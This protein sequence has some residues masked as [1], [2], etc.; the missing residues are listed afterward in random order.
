MF[1]L[2]K[3]RRQNQQLGLA[4]ATRRTQ[5]KLMQNLEVGDFIR[6]LGEPE[7]EILAR[8]KV[9]RAIT[10][11][12]KSQ[13]S[14]VEE[15][16]RTINERLLAYKKHLQDNPVYGIVWRVFDQKHF[17]SIHGPKP[18]LP[19]IFRLFPWN[20]GLLA[21]QIKQL[22]ASGQ[23]IVNTYGLELNCEPDYLAGLGVD[24]YKLRE[25]DPYLI[26]T[27]KK[28]QLEEILGFLEKKIKIFGQRV[29]AA[30]SNPEEV[31]ARLQSESWN[32]DDIQFSSNPEERERQLKLI[33][34]LDARKQFRLIEVYS[35]LKQAETLEKRLEARYTHK[36]PRT[37][38]YAILPVALGNDQ[39]YP[40]VAVHYINEDNLEL[41][42]SRVGKDVAGRYPELFGRKEYGDPLQ[43]FAIEVPSFA[44]DLISQALTIERKPT[45][46]T[47]VAFV[48]PIR[49][50]L[51]QH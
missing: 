20:L 50:A 4:L 33:G 22:K 15:D 34:C 17:S 25:P 42:E 30:R 51:P 12:L 39:K 6:Y 29:E 38:F 27:V 16:T 48:E 36:T 9:S 28:V 7:E 47:K 11:E 32:K 2:A 8:I 19:L 43:Y 3:Y 13:D 23:I 10:A 44:L 5:E 31:Y 45:Q 21:E 14:A 18:E 1:S 26:N 41:S 46:Q 49:K 35:V 40:P 24:D 37:N